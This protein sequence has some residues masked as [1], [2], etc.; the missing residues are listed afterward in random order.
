M[1][2]DNNFRQFLLFA[3][4]LIVPCF[5]LWTLAAG[6]LSMP[7]VGLADMILRAWFPE[8][9]DGLVSRGMDAVLLTNFGELNGRPVA[10]ELSE[11]QLGFVINPGV[12]T[13]SLP[14]Y[15]TLHFATQKDSY[16]ADFITGA[17]ILFP[18]VLLGLLSLCLKELM[19]NLGGLFMETARVPNGTF[20]A[21]FYQLNVLIV[22]TVAPILLWAWQSRDT[23]LLRGLLNLP[24]RSDGEE[25]A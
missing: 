16:L 17:I 14:F 8:I 5:A 9:V 3:F 12:L 1:Q 21:L 6:P 15:A 7:A 4:A 20:I 10:P 23:A 11:Y 22:P 13:Y 24:P 19:V 18:L 25:V 2:R